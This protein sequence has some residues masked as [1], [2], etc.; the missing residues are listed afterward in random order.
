MFNRAYQNQRLLLACHMASAPMAKSA[1]RWGADVNQQSSPIAIL[2][3]NVLLSRSQRAF[4]RYGRPNVNFYAE[5]IPLLIDHGADVDLRHRGSGVTALGYM[6]QTGYLEWVIKLVESGANVNGNPRRSGNTY[7][8]HPLLLACQA[9]GAI[10]SLGG[11]RNFNQI[12][13]YLLDQG[14]DVHKLDRSG[15]TALYHLSGQDRTV[16]LIRRLVNLGAEVNTDSS[17]RTPLHHAAENGNPHN[18]RE[19]LKR[20]AE[21]NSLSGNYPPIFLAAFHSRGREAE[22]FET[23][24]ILIEAGADLDIEITGNNPQ[25]REFSLVRRALALKEESEDS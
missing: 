14:A 16:G 25:I 7:P 12:I 2:A 23:V 9:R 19:L 24:R 4:V 18:V 11:E 17:R 6:V 20:G 5:M 21:V 22:R 1:L 15:Y 3:Q 13:L 8:Q 10:P